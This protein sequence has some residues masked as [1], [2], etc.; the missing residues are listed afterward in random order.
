[1]S[2]LFNT[3]KEVFKANYKKSLKAEENLPT[4]EVINQK[5]GGGIVCFFSGSEGNSLENLTR[6]YIKPFAERASTIWLL[7]INDSD[8]RDKL[9]TALQESV[10]FAYSFFGVG[11]DVTIQI[12][13]IEKNLWEAYN[14][15]F[16]RLFGDIP[17]Y[18]PDRHIGKYRN[19]INIYGDISHAQ[20]YRRWF[21][22]Q[23]ITLVMP[24][25]PLETRS[26]SSLDKEVKTNGKII[27]PKN[28]NTP[29][30][31]IAYWQNSL[32]DTVS[33]C[34]T[35]V[36]E[37][38]IANDSINKELHIDDRILRYYHDKGIDISVE[39]PLLCFLTGQIDDYVRR[40]KSTM[41]VKAIID[42]PVVIRGASW[43]HVNFY[44]KNALLDQNSDY[45]STRSLI[46]SALAIIDMSP[47]TVST[48]HDRVFRAAG[49]GTAFLTNH[50]EY[51]EKIL[52]TP[53]E[54]AFNFDERSI[55]DLVEYYVSNPTEAIE[56]GFRQALA[57]RK[58][59]TI[60]KYTDALVTVIEAKSLQLSNRPP[61]TQNFLHFPPLE[62][63]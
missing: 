61:G 31:L 60:E 25:I 36:A 53:I 16:V 1:M 37:A 59:F 44:G 5:M 7:N 10:W 42:L 32:P 3:I 12:D 11:Q 63:V 27:F 43:E 18:F 47:N 56:L 62:F 15:P 46:D 22:D 23:A 8:W 6:E 49:R 9:R 55:H 2:I 51:L 30:A 24:S 26:L 13:G 57:F 40:I 34:L 21:N 29:S 14:I 39:R 20:F 35:A 41:I 17:A 58:V 38:C 52:P 4:T 54:C 50:Q 28:G 45:A 19:S 33:K 48:P